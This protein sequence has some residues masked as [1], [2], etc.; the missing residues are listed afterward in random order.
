[1][2]VRGGRAYRPAAARSCPRWVATRKSRRVSIVARAS[3]IRTST[4]GPTCS[5]RF[6]PKRGK[7]REIEQGIGGQRVSGIHL[8]SRESSPEAAS[9]GLAS[10][11][12]CR[13]WPSGRQKLAAAHPRDPVA[14]V[15]KDPELLPRGSSR[16]SDVGTAQC[17]RC[18]AARRSRSARDARGLSTKSPPG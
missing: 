2:H 18:G 13:R 11:R 10:S 9:R 5:G 7:T 14:V 17:C 12:R 1:M 15:R 3:A 6:P 8:V 4:A 16:K